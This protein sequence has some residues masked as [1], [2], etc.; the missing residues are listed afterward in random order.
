MVCGGCG[1]EEDDAY[2]YGSGFGG[3][4]YFGHGKGGKEKDGNSSFHEITD[5]CEETT[6]LKRVVNLTGSEIATDVRIE[7]C[8]IAQPDPFANRPDKEDYSHSTG[9][10]DVTATHY[11]NKS[12]RCPNGNVAIFRR[13][14]TSPGH[15][16]DA[17]SPQYRVPI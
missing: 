6:V 16:T 12:V 14:L 15:F 7:E 2:G 13:E 1:E 10:D 9:S 3:N 17:P 11:Y 4:A 8:D 5:I